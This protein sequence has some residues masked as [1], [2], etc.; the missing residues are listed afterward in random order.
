MINTMRYYGFTWWLAYESQWF[1]FW[2]I[3]LVHSDFRG[4]LGQSLIVHKKKSFA[5]CGYPLVN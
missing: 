5:G 3:V 4:L 1:R 2:I